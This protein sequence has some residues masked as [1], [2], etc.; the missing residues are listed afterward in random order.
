MSQQIEKDH[1]TQALLM[2]F[3]EAFENVRGIFLDRG[4]SIFE[5]LDT[6]SA[7]EASQPI[8]PS[9]GTIAAQVAHMTFYIDVTVRWMHG[10]RA[11]QVDW[12]ATWN[13]VSAVTPQEWEASKQALRAG[14]EDLKGLAQ[15]TPWQDTNEIA[16]AMGM[17]AHNAFHLGQIRHALCVIKPER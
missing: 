11:Q 12:S 4:T 5:T 14:Y 2:M 1:F 6:I 15:T 16:G 3:A 17:L 9:C 13:T 7:E 8:S 10:D